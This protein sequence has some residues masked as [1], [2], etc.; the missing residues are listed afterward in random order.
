MRACRHARS[1]IERRQYPTTDQKARR[2]VGGGCALLLLRRVGVT[3][4]WPGFGIRSTVVVAG[5][6]LA[7]S[8]GMNCRFSNPDQAGRSSTYCSFSLLHN[9]CPK[10]LWPPKSRRATMWNCKT[11]QHLCPVTSWYFLPIRAIPAPVPRPILGA[12]VAVQM[13]HFVDTQGESDGTSN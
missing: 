10:H 9:K 11:V 5:R 8:T 12:T 13:M 6:R 4:A 1:A 2:V 3:V 7:C